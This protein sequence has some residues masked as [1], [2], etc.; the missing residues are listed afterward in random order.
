MTRMA[1]VAIAIVAVALNAPFGRAQPAG[2]RPAFDVASVKPVDTGGIIQARPARSGGR[3][4]WTTD[5]WYLISYA[6][7]FPFSRISGTIPKY[8]YSYRVDALTG[9]ASTDDQVRMMFRSLLTARFKLAAHVVSK[10]A[11]GY[12]LTI[13]KGGFKLA[14]AK[15]GDNPPP[16]PEWVVKDASTL[17]TEGQVWSIGLKTG[18][19]AVTGRRVSMKQFATILEGATGKMV[20]DQTGLPGAYYFAFRYAPDDSDDFGVP[21]LGTALQENLGLKLE[22]RRGQVEMLVV[23]HAE[24]NPTEN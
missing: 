2:A 7:N 12:A 18:G 4:T 21:T 23:D 5:L 11:D 17:A 24:I 10:E 1:P 22:K 15:D 3:I 14:E 8:T 6:Y 16:L 9:A 13:A 19:V 20:W